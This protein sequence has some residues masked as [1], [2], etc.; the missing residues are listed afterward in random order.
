MLQS[1]LE[2]EN[3]QIAPSNDGEDFVTQAIILHMN[4]TCSLVVLKLIFGNNLQN[5]K[6]C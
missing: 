2:V 3:F 1:K 4:N 5:L 6:L